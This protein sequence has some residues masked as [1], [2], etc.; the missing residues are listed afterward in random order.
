MPMLLL[1]EVWTMTAGQ[2][3]A[4]WIEGDRIADVGSAQD[5]LARYGAQR[6]VRPQRIT[7][8]L[9]DAH[10]HPLLWGQ[11][12]SMLDLSGLTN[13]AD[14]AAKVAGRAQSLPAGQW[15]RGGGYL[16]DHYPHKSWLDEA[17]PHHPV[18]L[19]SRDLHSSWANSL[20]L[21]LAGITHQTPQPAQGHIV[22]DQ[23]GQPTGYLLEGASGLVYRVTPPQSPADLQAGLNDLAKRGYT[24]THHMGW[25]G[26][27]WA[28]QVQLPL[29][30]WWAMDQGSW[31]GVNPGW[32]NPR[33][34]VAAVKFFADGAIGS[35]TAWMLE[36]YPD[37]SYGMPLNPIAEIRQEAQMALEAGF[38]VVTHAIGTRAVREVLGLYRQL[39]PLWQRKQLQSPL[40]LEHAQHVHDADLSSLRGLPVA[41]SLQPIHLLEDARLVREHQPGREHQAFRLREL[42][43]SGLIN[44][45]GSDAPVAPPDFALGLQAATQHLLNPSQSLSEAEV[46][47]G[48]TRGAALAAGWPSHGQIVVGSPADL[49]LWEG[50]RVVG[51]VLDGVLEWL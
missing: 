49:T 21:A 30:L 3:Q 38:S 33:L 16:L 34:H 11:Q 47:W 36:A 28:K 17:A 32:H 51:R 10:T 20:A 40:R 50:G 15:I 44:A 6:V 1:G 8:G 19:Q 14:I 23:L 37:G 29:R 22:Q 27:D 39:A 42:W 2:A 45:F 41:L 46:L 5:L 9:H 7:P 25:C 26:L 4:V 43:D 48:F 13:P 18:L 12:L 24:A 31:Q 35:R